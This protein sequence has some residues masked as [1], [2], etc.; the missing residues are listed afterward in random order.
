[1]SDNR[2]DDPFALHAAAAAREPDLAA[3][4]AR[5]VVAAPQPTLA[6]PVVAAPDAV[7]ASGGEII[8]E[9]QSPEA[10][11]SPFLL[12]RG[13]LVGLMVSAMVIGLASSTLVYLMKKQAAE[14]AAMPW[15][16]DI[17]LERVSADLLYQHYV[18]RMNDGTLYEIIPDTDEGREYFL[19]FMY[20]VTDVK[21]A[22]SIRGE[23][24]EEEKQ[25]LLDLEQ[26]FLKLEDLDVSL[27]ITRS[28]GTRFVH[29]GT[30]PR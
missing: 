17:A 14:E 9:G 5:P 11:R 16:Q 26:R 28:D 10:P 15:T 3:T 18:G 23:L 2:P 13:P 12:R 27:D 8:A 24:T 6:S 30:A 20:V 19:A 29:D 4:T 25:Y 22:E 1:M 7:P 21:A